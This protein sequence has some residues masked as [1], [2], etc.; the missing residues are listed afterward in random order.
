MIYD[1]RIETAFSDDAKA[2]F[3]NAAALWIG[4]PHRHRIAIPG[5]GIDCLNLM[6]E[7]YVASGVLPPYQLP[8]YHHGLGLGMNFNVMEWIARRV[9]IA[10]E[11]PAD[12]GFL[13]FG[14][15]AIFSVGAQANHVGMVFDGTVVHACVDKGTV[16][17]SLDVLDGAVQS[18]FRLREAGFA[19]RPETLNFREI[20]RQAIL[21]HHRNA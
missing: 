16:V 11:V 9:L 2:R 15:L 21:G 19:I 7:L 17:E 1:Q 4:T 12:P 20:R 8:Y 13:A 14:D 6:R 3:R 18:I 5:K 10:D